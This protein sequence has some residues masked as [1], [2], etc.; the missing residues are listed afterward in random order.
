MKD[1]IKSTLSDV[2]G[3]ISSNRVF[4][5]LVVVF[6]L[7]TS[8]YITVTT[9]AIPDI[10]ESWIYLVGIFAGAALGGKATEAAKSFKSNPDEDR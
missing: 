7:A 1:F 8:S 3:E 4:L 5:A 6:I 9:G 2:N 10:S